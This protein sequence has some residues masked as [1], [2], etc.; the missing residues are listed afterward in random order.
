MTLIE[1]IWK[2]N[3]NV[4]NGEDENVIQITPHLKNHNNLFNLYIKIIQKSVDQIQNI[5]YTLIILVVR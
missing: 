4:H 2:T 1:S 5:R 3:N